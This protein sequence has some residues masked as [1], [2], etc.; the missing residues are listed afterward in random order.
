MRP[1]KL[2]IEG[3]TAFREPTVVDFDG[4]ELFVLSGPTGSG[5]SSL[6]DAMTFALY[7]SIPRYNDPKL[8]H[9]VVSQG[10]Q[11]ARVRFDFTIQDTPYTAVRV[12]RR[13]KRGDG[14]GAAT[15]E[16]RLEGGD[17]ILAGSARELDE[18]VQKLFGLSFEQFT[19]CVVLPQGEFAR[20]LHST[21]AERQSLLKELLRIFIYTRMGQLARQRQAIAKQRL[22]L[23]K[24]ELEGLV[25]ATKHVKREVEQRVKR[26]RKLR[27][28]VENSQSELNKL[29]QER[30][31]KDEAAKVEKDNEKKLSKIKKPKELD[32]IVSDQQLANQE[33]TKRRKA[34]EKAEKN[35]DNEEREYSKLPES[36]PIRQLVEIYK[37]CEEEEKHLKAAKKSAAESDKATKQAETLLQTAKAELEIAE[38]K[39]KELRRKHAAYH[40]AEGLD[41]G[42][43]CPVCLRP[44]DSVPEHPLPPALADA[45]KVIQ[46][47]KKNKEQAEEAY[48]DAVSGSSGDAAKVKELQSRVA[49]FNKRLKDAAPLAELKKQLEVNAAALQRVKQ[50][51]QVAEDARKAERKAIDQINQIERRLKDAWKE[52]DRM[53]DSVASLEPPAANREDLSSS[54]EMLVTWSDTHSKVTTEKAQ[55]LLLDVKTIVEQITEKRKSLREACAEEGVEVGMDDDVRDTV[56]DA[57]ARAEEEVKQIEQAI[58]KHAELTKKKEEAKIAAAVSGSLA[59]HL[60]ANAFERWL[61]QEA[62]DQLVLEGSRKLME[63]SSGDYSFHLDERLNF[64]IVD[65]RNAD[66]IRS[67]RTLSGGE[68][69]LASL[70]LALTL[71]EQVADLATEGA[72][73]LESIFLDEGFGSLDPDTLEMVASTIEDLG[74]HGRIVGLI[75]HVKE[76]AD[77]IPVQYRV[78]KGPKTA[79][80]EKIVF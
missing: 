32:S 53:R 26:L 52:Y 2:E 70:A 43:P 65:H 77:R 63:L 17:K 47:A 49:A 46:K 40:L 68:T 56:V 28:M 30:L 41:S 62:F 13:Q 22:E 18:Q 76:L 3:F 45:E 4:S 59:R 39:V 16:A 20:F 34:R 69:F 12:I 31:R 10:L 7:G 79:S 14:W 78:N 74:A 44:L 73:R 11:E 9:P 24:E 37:Q 1:I 58:E 61:L 38:T 27:K 60:S 75:T 80:V 36:D 51:R 29:D 50:A 8:I 55:Q 6:I 54:W 48:H 42:E 72:A 25:G 66:E 57:L 71:S 19:T 64:D 67:S 23:L 35:L 15:K 21:P 5:K 33:L